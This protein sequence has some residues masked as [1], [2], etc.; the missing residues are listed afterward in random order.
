MSHEIKK[1][2]A[3]ISAC[4]CNVNCRYDGKVVKSDLYKKLSQY[5]DL[6]LVC[7]EVMGGMKTPRL[8]SEI[9]CSYDDIIYNP[10]TPFLEAFA[11]FKILNNKGK[12]NTTFFIS[13]CKMASHLAKI[14]NC[15]Y[16]F[17]KEKSPS[18]GVKYRYDGTFSKKLVNHGGL[19]SYC[20]NKNIKIIS[21]EDIDSFLEEYKKEVENG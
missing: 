15:K 18:C 9:V 6:V 1:E 12:D 14:N 19:L 21:S 5:F 13:G 4:L 11:N 16:A 3:I 20:L 10:N 7:P 17:L 8:P 2:K